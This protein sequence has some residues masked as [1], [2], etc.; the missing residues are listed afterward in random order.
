MEAPATFDLADCIVS[1][2]GVPLSGAG[3]GSFVEISQT[4]DSWSIAE[5]VDGSVA[6]GASNSKLFDVK[7]V[8]LGT[9]KLN[10]YLSGVHAG[11]LKP[12]ILIADPNGNDLFVAPTLLIV[13][14]ATWKLTNKVEDREWTC[15][16]LGGLLVVGGV[17]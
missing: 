11:K 6:A 8:L 17:L 3:T 1:V 16:A 12:K 13:K 7:I 5:G 14:Q 10:A 2:G 9:S 15:K 4:S